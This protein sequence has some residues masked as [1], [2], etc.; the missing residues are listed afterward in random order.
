MKKLTA[1]IFILTLIS[2]SLSAGDLPQEESV[3]TE[4]SNSNEKSN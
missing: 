4:A 2:C 1:I 3:N